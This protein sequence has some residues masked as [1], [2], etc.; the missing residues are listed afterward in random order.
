MRQAYNAVY[1]VEISSKNNERLYIEIMHGSDANTGSEF[2]R[3]KVMYAVC[4]AYNKNNTLAYS[5]S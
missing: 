1:N 4:I 2:F 3:V 5:L